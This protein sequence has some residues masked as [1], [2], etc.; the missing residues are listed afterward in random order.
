MNVLHIKIYPSE[1]RESSNNRKST[2]KPYMLKYTTD[3]LISKK[4]KALVCVQ[5]NDKEKLGK[6]NR[7]IADVCLNEGIYMMKILKS[8]LSSYS[9]TFWMIIN[10]SSIS[11]Y[12]LSQGD[13]IKIGSFHYRINRM[14]G[15]YNSRQLET[16]SIKA[17]FMSEGGLGKVFKDTPT[18][19]SNT[20]YADFFCRVCRETEDSVD[21]PFISPCACTGTM[22][23]MHYNCFSE[24]VLSKLHIEKLDFHQVITWDG[25]ICESCKTEIPDN[26]KYNN[27]N[28][29][30]LS[31]LKPHGK[32]ISLELSR[33]VTKLQRK[34]IIVSLREKNYFCF[35]IT[36]EILPNDLH[37]IC[38]FQVEGK[39][40]L[41][42]NE[43]LNMDTMVMARKTIEMPLYTKCLFANG[44]NLIRFNVKEKMSIRNFFCY[45][46]NRNHSP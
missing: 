1:P 29:S 15:F 23:Y 17:S 34:I 7:L 27:K 11:S 9:D 25:I 24:W 21:N 26:F 19:L 18:D 8:M 37:K 16:H 4:G 20:L 10:S 28:F 35:G 44:D 14:K 38:T 46:K 41:L 30:L 33:T 36:G 5:A 12:Q 6:N 40:I 2:Q 32:H 22:G 42:Q 13:I 31:L 3:F 45:C 39:K 43:S